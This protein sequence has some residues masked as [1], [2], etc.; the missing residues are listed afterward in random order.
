M[1]QLPMF[2]RSGAAA[3]KADLSRTVA[4]MKYLGN[5]KKNF[6]SVHIAGTNG[7]GSVSHLLAA[8]FQSAGYKTGLFTSPHLSDFRERIRINGQMIPKRKV[9]A[10]I[11]QH[12]V[13]LRQNELSFFEM[14]A[15]LAFDYFAKENIDIAIIETGMGGRLDSTNVIKPE[16]SIISNIGFDHT[17]FLGDTLEKIAIEK[18]GIIKKEIP[19]LIGE[20]QKE[21]QHIFSEKTKKENAEI[22]FAEDICTIDIE[23]QKLIPPLL[24]IQANINEKHF[25]LNTSLAGDYQLKNIKTAVAAWQILKYK[26]YKLSIPHLQTAL[27]NVEK[28]TGFTGRW[29]YRKANCPI[30][31]DTAHNF[32]GLI[33]VSEMLKKVKYKKLHIVLGMVDDKDHSKL[34]NLLPEDASYYFCKADIPRG[35]DAQKL[36]LEART[37][38]RDG[39]NYESVKNALKNA[40][41]S[42]GNADLIFVGGSTFT[43][44]EGLVEI[45]N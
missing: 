14:S 17:A 2:Q 10:F 36:M 29:T 5:P 35:F 38:G 23:E 25:N 33:Y 11:Q 31:F 18:A 4:L 43:V 30:I 32:E 9:S 34:L 44:A 6:K 39:Q 7:K 45:E 16:L 13:Y 3:Y 42:A 37:L 20:K 22:F 19:V 24:K 41:K 15:G 40:L 8:V 27:K 1:S 26:G 21:I 12:E 28:L